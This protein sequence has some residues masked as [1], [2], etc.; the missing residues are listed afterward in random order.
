MSDIGKSALYSVR[1]LSPSRRRATVNHY[2]IDPIIDGVLRE[3][4]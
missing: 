2:P 1:P 4:R 3:P